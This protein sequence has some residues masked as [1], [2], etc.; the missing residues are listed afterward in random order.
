MTP[1]ERKSLA[2]QLLTNPLFSATFDELEKAAI[3]AMVYATDDDIRQRMA[4]RVQEV[5]NFKHDCTAALRA[6]MPE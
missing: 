5:R 2:E 1:Q 6:H 3:E 4:F